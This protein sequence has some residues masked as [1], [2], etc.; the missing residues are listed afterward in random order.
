MCFTLLHFLH[1]SA[2]CTEGRP[3]ILKDKNKE[4]TEYQI[5][6][7]SFDPLKSES[8]PVR[9]QH[10]LYRVMTLKT[11]FCGCTLILQSKVLP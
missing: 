4:P 7:D 5:G 11:P 10:L 3:K 1:A 6:N 8:N 2:D 9:K